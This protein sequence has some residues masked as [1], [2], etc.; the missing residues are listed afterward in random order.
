[1]LNSLF[2]RMKARLPKRGAAYVMNRLLLLLSFSSGRRARYSR[3]TRWQH[4]GSLS[5]ASQLLK[6]GFAG[7]QVE[8]GAARVLENRN[9]GRRP[10]SGHDASGEI[11][12]VAEDSG[13]FNRAAGDGLCDV[14]HVQGGLRAYR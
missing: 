3:R 4:R 10:A 7:H 13:F 6:N 5:A 11:V 1:M 9:I 8:M 12:E 2:G 14:A